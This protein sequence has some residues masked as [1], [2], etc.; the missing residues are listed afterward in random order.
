[1]LKI[2]LQRFGRKH[3]PTFRVVLTDSRSGPKSGK[4]LEVLGSYNP[5]Q[6]K[7]AIVLNKKKLHTGFQK[8][9]RLLIP[10]A[11]F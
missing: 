9:P 10:C 5:R 11:I 7:D 2:R 8:E 3:D 6:K 4:F 1:M